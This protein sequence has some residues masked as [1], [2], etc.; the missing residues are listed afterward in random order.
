MSILKS[1]PFQITL[2]IL[3]LILLAGFVIPFLIKMFFAGLLMMFNNPLTALLISLA[4]LTGMFFNEMA[5]K[6]DNK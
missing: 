6:V 1:A 3:I 2:A 4:F 5:G